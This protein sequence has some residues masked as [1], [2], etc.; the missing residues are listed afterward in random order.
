MFA[1]AGT[2]SGHLVEAN[3]DLSDAKLKPDKY[4]PIELTFSPED[5]FYTGLG[6]KFWMNQVTWVSQWRPFRL[7]GSR[8]LKK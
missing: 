7:C 8:F 6:M 2:L 1:C 4:F 3:A 5:L